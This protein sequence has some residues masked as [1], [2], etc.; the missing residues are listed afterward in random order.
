MS[1]RAFF[2]RVHGRLTGDQCDRDLAD[3]LASHL[4]RHMSDNMRAGMTFDEA[5]R[6]ALLALGGLA[7]TAEAVRDQRHLAVLEATMQDVR[8][9]IRLLI[10]SPVYTLAAIAALAVGIG[11]NTAVFS[12]VNGVLLKALPYKDPGQLIV[13]SEQLPNA[14]TKFPFSPPDFETFRRVAGSYSGMA[15]YQSTEYELSGISTP[16]RLNGARVSPDLFS[17]LGIPPTIGRTLMPDDDR[18]N[19]RV[20]VVSAG[21]WTRTFGRDPSLLGRSI[22]LDGRQYTVVGIMPDGVEFPPRGAALNGTPADVFI[23]ISFTPIER[24]GFGDFFNN[25]VLARLKPG[26][27]LTQARAELS[28]LAGTIIDQYPPPMRSLLEGK[29]SLLAAPLYEET[30][31]ASRQLL[32]VLTGAVALV[33]LM[34]CAD[35]ASLVLTRSAGRQRELAI[36]AALGA[37]L[38]RLI[39]QLL[40]ESLV[41]ALAGCAVGVALAFG[42]MRVMVASFGDRLPR[43]EAITFDYRVFFF[44]LLLAVVTPLVF[45]AAPAIRVARDISGTALKDGGRSLTSGRRQSR[46][47]KS[48]VV[49]QSAVALLLSVAAV[50]F[51]RSFA[52]LVE[53]D[54]GFHSQQAARATVTLPV[55]RYETVA[56]VAAFYT[57]V[58]EEA[59]RMP[60]AMAV[61]SGDDLPLNVRARLAVTGDATARRIPT[62]SRLIAATWTAGA[63]FRALGIPLRR[64]RSLT[65]S[66]RLDSQRV[67]VINER[68]ANMLW[69]DSDPIGHQIK[70]GVEASPS[71]WMTIVGVVGD[72]KQGG[73]DTPA[74]PQAYAPVAQ[75]ESGSPLLRTLNLVV[76]SGR[77]GDAL[78]ADMRTAIQRLDGSLPVTVQTLDEMLADSARPQRFSASI[79]MLFASIALLLAGLGIYGVLANAVMQRKQE[80]GV[81]MALGATTVNVLWMVLGRALL[82]VGIGLVIGLASALA[83]TRTMSSLLFEVRTTDAVSFAGAAGLLTL[84]AVLAGLIPAWR[85]TRVNPIIALRAG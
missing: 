31:G 70:W 63:Y 16:Q 30:V 44:A 59:E 58:V 33:L 17:V 65:E 77:S 5:R 67:V 45:G 10:Q 29:F 22:W 80:I 66:D 68:L 37:S 35:V 14:P 13:L 85:A 38:A 27:S 47:L 3:E 36:R 12:I 26:V 50:L 15:A 52:R 6:N 11:A 25:T 48:L 73:R 71:P 79:M 34:G 55:G 53:T 84:I 61:G 46:L 42:L 8:Y 28:R 56:K 60:G 18:Q 24:Q 82:L 64:G 75:D 39:R 54:P 21:L 49:G 2:G 43:V 40:T 72:V 32:L 51:V 69:P 7:Q 19:A 1:L 78:V 83:V 74:M 20:A 23:P 81:R 57:R 4:D 76:R 9:A 41:L 62:S